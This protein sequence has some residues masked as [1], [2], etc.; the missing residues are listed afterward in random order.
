MIS[1]IVPV[2]NTSKYLRRCLDSIINQTYKD[3]EIIIVDDGSTDVSPSICDEYDK[4]YNNV[5]VIHKDNAGL[6]YARNSGMKVMNGKYVMFVDSD[7]FLQE[8]MIEQL[9]ADLL[10]ENA[11][12][13]IGGFT[14]F[15][16]SSYKIIEN[17]LSKRSFKNA[18]VKDVLVKMLGKKYDGSDYIEMSVWKVL[19]ST[20]IIRKNKIEFPSEREY[21]SED[22]IFDLQYYTKA[23]VVTVS[24]N[25][26]YCYCDNADSLTMSYRSNRFN[27][28]KK[29]YYELCNLTKKFDIYDMAGERIA[30]NLISNVRHCIK[31]E[32]KYAKQNGKI[33]AMNNI[34]KICNDNI[35]QDV[36]KEWDNTKVSLKP[37]IFN[38][39]IKRKLFYLIWIVAKF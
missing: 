12:T 37:K 27:L 20:E 6:G 23:Q 21:I 10:K 8:N 19:F 22:I 5:Q 36:W 34:K 18:Y 35:L 32:V 4:K 33:F 28:Q 31:L 7:D 3:L 38:A 13:C 1:V 39:L 24:S 25:C 2:Y 14:R 11:D 30:N 9:Y 15:Y 26:G 29:M 16:E 17:P